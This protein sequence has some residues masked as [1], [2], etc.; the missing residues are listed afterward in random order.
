MSKFTDFCV[1]TRITFNSNKPTVSTEQRVCL[2]DST[3][4]SW[5]GVFYGH[6]SRSPRRRTYRRSLR[7][8]SWSQYSFLR[9]L[10]T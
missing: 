2:K 4:L 6:E 7:S 5:V 8:S 3:K 1:Y 9:R 10:T